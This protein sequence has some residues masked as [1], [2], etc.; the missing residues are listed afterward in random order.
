MDVTTVIINYQTPDLLEAAVDSFKE[1]YPGVKLLIVD[2]GSEDH[3][4]EAIETMVAKYPQTEG[5]YFKENIYHGPAMHEVLSKHLMTSFAFFLDSDTETK[6][7][8]F[9]EEMI[10]EASHE[11]VYGVG[12]IIT[13]NERGFKSEKGIDVL[14]TPF[15]LIKTNV[16]SKFSP[17]IHH[18]QPTILNFKEA[19]NSG[20]KLKGYPV[21][22]YIFHHWR[23]T[24]KRFGYGL[25]V[26]GKVD[27]ILNKLGF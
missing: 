25:G 17:F 3:S 24:A 26:K 1:F 4:K 7:K 18:G 5:Q 10:Q 2:N 27:Y 9:L 13:T 21:S 16:Y 11:K 22:D 19:Q 12:E 14:L 15:M 8:G 20:Y 23:G 6:K